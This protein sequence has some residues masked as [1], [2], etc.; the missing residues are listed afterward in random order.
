MHHHHHHV[1]SA[2][3]NAFL[4]GAGLN[5]I[6]VCVEASFGF[7]T[8]SLSLLADAGHNLSDVFAL[9]LAWGANHLATLQPTDRHTYGYRRATILAALFSSMILFVTIGF[10]AFE[11]SQRLFAA[12]EVD[13]LI[14]I[15]V[16]GVGILVNFATAA[17]FFKDQAHDLNIK[18]AYLHMIADALVSL[19][20][21]VGGVIIYF[22]DW[23]LI[24]PL[25]GL[26]IVVV[27]AIS[28]WGLLRDSFNLAL[29]AVPENIDLPAIKDFLL[30]NPHVQEIHDLHVW[31]MSTTEVALT[32]HL[33]CDTDKLDDKFVQELAQE[34]NAR[35]HVGHST[36]QI[37]NGRCDLECQH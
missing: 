6:Y 13:S 27:I 29:D 26:I 25:L 11:S 19:A 21:V 7:F 37:E 5:I 16:A 31:A 3:N 20:V 36:I 23:L 8:H 30:S 15:I 33:L 28:A 12:I 22:T 34:L 18:G 32:A 14:I 35:Y 1:P 9:L 17:L 2:R 4:L 10:I 24:D